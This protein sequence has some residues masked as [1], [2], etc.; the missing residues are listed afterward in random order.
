M[1]LVARGEVDY[2]FGT[3]LS[4]SDRVIVMSE[5]HLAAL[6]HG[7]PRLPERSL[8]IYPPA[9]LTMTSATREEARRRAAEAFGFDPGDFIL[10]YIGRLYRGKGLET[11]LEAMVILRHHPRRITALIIGGDANVE[12]G[13]PR[14][15]AQLKQRAAELGVSDRVAWTGEFPWNTDFASSMLRAADACALPFDRGVQLNNSSVAAAVAHGLPLITTRGDVLEQAFSA[16]GNVLL[17]PPRDPAALARAVEQLADDE[18]LRARLAAGAAALSQRY[19]SWAA[20]TA[21]TAAAL[22]VRTEPAT[23]R[24]DSTQ[25]LP[26]LQGAS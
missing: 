13:A 25:T 26:P 24:Q 22:G 16:D 12:R 5:I 21:L 3:L 15:E 23:L 9:F 19:F 1:A 18:T 2:S 10:A 4:D 8:L 11:L 6:T 7:S 14:L 17:C 20:S